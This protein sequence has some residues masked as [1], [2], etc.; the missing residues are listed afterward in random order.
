MT[1]SQRSIKQIIIASLYII[2]ASAIIFLVVIN[3]FPPATIIV[4]DKPFIEPLQVVRYGKI[5]L[6]DGFSDFWAEISNPNDDF[7]VSQLDYSFILSNSN[8][9]ES[10]KSG[11]T[12]ILPGDKRR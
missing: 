10:K 9:E 3:L 5:D 2:T 8:G 4:E 11:I 6:G 7:G 1:S 12:Y